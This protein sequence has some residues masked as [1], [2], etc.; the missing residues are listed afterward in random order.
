MWR[1]L[2]SA[3]LA[4]VLAASSSHAQDPVVFDLSIRGIRAGTLSFSGQATDG[5]YT[6]SGR[7]ESAGLVGLVRQ[8]RYDGR[9]KA[10]CGRAASRRRATANRPIPESGNRNRS[11]NTGA[12][13]RR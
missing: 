10:A 12:E 3:V 11:W 9:R 13:F 2:A 4:A 7:L 6:V 1:R 8:V 5:R